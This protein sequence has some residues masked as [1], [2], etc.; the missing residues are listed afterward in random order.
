MEGEEEGEEKKKERKRGRRRRRRP[1][2]AQ[3][4]K[5]LSDQPSANLPRHGHVGLPG[6]SEDP[7]E[8][9]QEEKV[10]K[11]RGHD[12]DTLRERREQKKGGE[13]EKNQT[14]QL[15]LLLFKQPQ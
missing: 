5:A 2:P 4:Q 11:G 12:A 13:E 7:A 15:K 10:Q 14:Q 8:G 1:T 9:C 3:A 6:L